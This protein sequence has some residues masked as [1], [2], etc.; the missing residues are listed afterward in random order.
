MKIENKE[1][2]SR[3][4]SVE[5]FLKRGGYD[6]SDYALIEYDDLYNYIEKLTMEL[7]SKRWVR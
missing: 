7:K 4:I 5:E 1:D 6:Q 2:P 3:T